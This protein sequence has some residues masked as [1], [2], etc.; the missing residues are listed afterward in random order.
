VFDWR[1]FRRRP[2]GR[3]VI[4]Q[5]PFLTATSSLSSSRKTR[6]RRMFANRAVP[7][8]PLSVPC[9]PAVAGL[10]TGGKTPGPLA[11]R[12]STERG[13]NSIFALRPQANDARAKCVI[14]LADKRAGQYE[15]QYLKDFCAR[16]LDVPDRLGVQLAAV[17]PPHCQGSS[18]HCVDQA[19]RPRV[20]LSR[21]RSCLS[22]FSRGK[23]SHS[24]R[25]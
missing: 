24:R 1:W 12:H 6:F 18:L 3:W 21:S 2:A 9:A 25:P 17:R 8:R 10:L 20:L 23:I 15:A 5:R 11:A 19:A 7:T 16:L 14:G 22:S 13:R 4:T